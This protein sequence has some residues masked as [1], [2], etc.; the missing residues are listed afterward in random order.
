MQRHLPDR[1]GKMPRLLRMDKG[2]E[3]SVRELLRFLLESGKVDGVLSLAR[4]GKNGG[5][6]YSL[7]TN[8]DLLDEAVPLFPLMPANA[9]KVLSRLTLVEPAGRPVAR[10]LAGRGRDKGSPGGLQGCGAGSSRRGRTRERISPR[11]AAI[12]DRVGNA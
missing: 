8:P 11:R 1:R 5:L 2:A 7:I 4:T 9:A 12:R 6:T 3:E 10:L